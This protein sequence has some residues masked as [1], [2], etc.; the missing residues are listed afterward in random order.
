[1]INCPNKSLPEFQALISAYGEGR[2]TAA[3]RNNNEAIPTVE[4]AATLLGIASPNTV[5]ATLKIV[6]ALGTDKTQKLYDKFYKSNPEKFY[7]ELTPLA[8]K[9]QVELLRQYNSAN[10]PGSLQDMLAG[11]LADL[12]YTVEIETAKEKIQ[13]NFGKKYNIVDKEFFEYAG[14]TY[15]I[16]TD[17]DGDRVYLKDNKQVSYVD[18]YEPALE[19][20]RE[21]VAK[22]EDVEKEKPT[23]YYSNL[24]VPG[25]TNYTENEIATPGITPSIKGHA[26]FSTDNGIGWF[27]SDDK[28][29]F[30]DDFSKMSNKEIEKL[31]QEAQMSIDE[32]LQA[33]NYR[34]GA[35]PSKTRRIL[36]VQSD[37]FQKGR[38]K[39][40]LITTD[41]DW[42]ESSYMQHLLSSPEERNKKENKKK[43]E[44]Q[45]LQLLNKDGNW[46]PF[47]IKSIVQDSAKKGYEK[48]LFPTGDTA[49]KI[50][51]H[52][53][54]EDFKKEKESRIKELE[55]EKNKGFKNKFIAK[56]ESGSIIGEADTE[57]VVRDIASSFGINNPIIE[58][59]TTEI[60]I[61][62][63]DREIQQLQEELKRVETEG[64]GALKPIYDFYENRVG[65]TLRKIY[66][67]DKVER[68]KDEYGNEW[69]QV[70]VVPEVDKST[71]FYQLGTSEVEQADKE[72]NKIIEG[73]IT[74][75]GGTIT[76]T[77]DIIINGE[78]INAN[79]VADVIRKAIQVADGKAKIDTLPE[80]AAHIFI[81]WLPK[82][83][84][85]RKKLMA[86]VRN[87]PEYKKV[88]REYKNN[89]AYQNEDGTVNEEK[90]AIETAGQI[91]AGAIVGRYKDSKTM[92]LLD[93][94]LRWIKELLAGKD[95][96]AYQVAAK[97]I[98]AGSTGKLDL[99]QSFT[100]E[101]YYYQR[102][103]EYEEY[104]QKL[105][106]KGTDAQKIVIKKLFFDQTVKRE[107]DKGYKD[108]EGNSYN[109]V[110]SRIY[111]DSG[112][113]DQYKINAEWGKQVDKILE[114]IL[115]NKLLSEIE[116]L[117]VPGTLIPIATQGVMESFYRDL[118][119]LVG[120]LTADGSIALAQ[121]VT[122][123]PFDNDPSK[124]VAGSIDILIVHPNGDTTVV[125]LKTASKKIKISPTQYSI[126]YVT[127][128]PVGKGSL[129]VDGQN[130]G[131]ST[132]KKD[133][134]GIQVGSYSKMNRLQ[135]VEIREP[136]TF[137]YFL[138]TKD[139]V[140]TGYESEGTVEHKISENRDLVDKIVPVDYTGYK[141]D[142]GN[143]LEKESKEDLLSEE[144]MIAQEKL[145]KDNLNDTI[146]NL[147]ANTK[148]FRTFLE[149]RER[150]TNLGI[151]KQTMSSID[152]LLA[153][154]EAELNT[155]ADYSTV[156]TVFLNAAK[157]QL[158]RILPYI[159]RR[160]AN[161]DLVNAN[162]TEFPLML[163]VIAE[164]MKTFEDLFILREV[165]TDYQLKVY[166]QVDQLLRDTSTAL[167]SAQSYVAD[168]Y[169]MDNAT[170]QAVKNEILQSRWKGLVY[171]SGLKTLPDMTVLGKELG[172]LGGN[173]IADLILK[174]ITEAKEESRENTERLTEK[175]FAAANKLR[176][177][178]ITNYDFMKQIGDDGKWN[179]LAVNR[180]G[181]NYIKLRRAAEEGN[182]DP[183]TGTY[184]K[185]R[186]ILDLATALAEDILYNKNLWLRKQAL[187]SFMNAETLSVDPNTGKVII[188]N[189]MYHKYTDQFK[190]ERNEY[191]IVKI[192][193]GF[194]KW[195][196]RDAT[197]ISDEMKDYLAKEYPGVPVTRSWEQE[198][199]KWRNR[200]YVENPYTTLVKDDKGNITGATRE[201]TGDAAWFPIDKHV[202]ARLIAGNGVKLASD[203]YIKLVQPTTTVEKAQAEYYNTY[204]EIM[205]MLM[206]YLP[207]EANYWFSQGNV[208]FLQANIMNRLSE[209]GADKMTI[210]SSVMKEA[211]PSAYFKD[212][213]EIE[214]SRQL[215]LAF[216]NGVQD[217]A[218][219]K[220]L[221]NEL[222]TLISNKDTMSPATYENRHN[223]IVKALDRERSKMSAQKFH[224][225]L[226]DGIVAFIK[227]AE[228]FIALSKAQGVLDIL[229]K[230]VD[231]LNFTSPAGFFTK[232]TTTVK[233]ID[234]R[235]KERIKWFMDNEFY[236]DE[237]VSKTFGDWFVKKL[238]TG[239]SIMSIGANVTGMIN[240]AFI[241]TLNNIIES[242]G[243]DF[244]RRESYRRMSKLYFS[245]FLPGY[246][247]TLGQHST[248]DKSKS[249]YGNK[250]AG[251]KIEALVIEFNM[252]DQ[253][254][255]RPGSDSWMGKFFGTLGY[256]GYEAGEYMVQSLIGNSILDSTMI[257]GYMTDSKGNPLLDNNGEKI[258][259]P[260]LSVFDAYE[261]D[262]N[263]G[264]VKLKAGYSLAKKEKYSI[265]HKI[266]KTN[267]RIHANTRW[268]VMLERY[269]VG[270]MLLQFHKWVF[271]NF[272][273][274]FELPKYNE[275]LGMDVEGRYITLWNF[276]KSLAEL[277]DRAQA[278]D[279]LTPLQKNNLK[280]DLADAL[281]VAALFGMYYVLRRIADGIPDDDP[282]IK[283]MVNWLSREADRGSQ[284]LSLFIPIWGTIEGWRLIKNPI[285][286]TSSIGKFVTL[287]TDMVQYP[288]QDDE[289]RYYQR[290]VFSGQLKVKKAAYDIIPIYKLVNEWTRLGQ[291][292]NFFIQ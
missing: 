266:W 195:V 3:W 61:A 139:G 166:K 187:N 226:T 55:K 291:Q 217:V 172:S 59:N 1:M 210:L 30:S 15:K 113:G 23:Q 37:L 133:N 110:T 75:L 208:P 66:G 132:S 96:D 77:G 111:G 10:N 65:N 57:I 76:Y 168:K 176:E 43:R 238:M 147:Y 70:P 87:R 81:H 152:D 248:R 275:A 4:Q 25:G 88:M 63:I 227:M 34:P 134:Y 54:L 93:K 236:S 203:K 145:Q 101:E 121:V 74:S 221:E 252:I 137:N 7:S 127:R 155:G 157:D 114:G 181:P 17:D 237:K 186:K 200:N 280:K 178:S 257:E 85:L 272:L 154:I 285:A 40:D 245:E 205:E 146:I 5:N 11:I 219:L 188:E 99:T 278:W 262:E 282:Y 164:Y 56:T 220:F 67:K 290:G 138:K 239:T 135:G 170:N 160:D 92:S 129:L 21:A 281:F 223:E 197:N 98:L 185:Y 141:L 184:Y 228:N 277:K 175:I 82:N 234:S 194:A 162:E 125:D 72:L 39:E 215:P 80:E 151:F 216:M 126:S 233:G 261:F 263:T 247:K 271:P 142:L 109:G 91:L 112:L 28:S 259:A 222:A 69:Y 45:F 229:D 159:S 73:F 268:K 86:D 274:R 273:Q 49:S 193:N 130:N 136:Y 183:V 90:I 169:I 199:V 119:I 58:K 78:K 36:E 249:Y 224:P 48:V 94:F 27:R 6:E 33:R 206:K 2:A 100:G 287:I 20:K 24:T 240:N 52:S 14:S 207:P 258:P 283:K 270:K 171:Q 103:P 122:A 191:M 190:S 115:Q 265:T 107:E 165:G 60:Q 204:I 241:A 143:Y 161:G 253:E 120:N 12:S 38:D 140:I 201:V 42:S 64:F 35:I 84:A 128:R 95:F 153:A 32:L 31:A 218:R 53:T 26:Q 118:S 131:L 196:F 46:I 192:T 22:G 108:A 68:I 260:K 149:A 8:G 242:I 232:G 148:K 244:F 235:T 231:L 189:G 62:N 83:S 167:T 163:G 97:Q 179:G 182:R 150:A 246:V 214:Q 177:L 286:V 269:A 211:I 44:N 41:L 202:E 19:A 243:S 9:Q 102:T 47:F 116:T 213:G 124:R 156:Y 254:Y 50:E 180:L 51:G 173:T 13:T 105:A 123:T 79:A 276:L 264:T 288:F 29:S 255:K 71:I 225:D 174:R 106:D 158:N 251:S 250:K 18:V 230:K 89:P 144:E 256:G 16:D 198:R 267:E 289:E 279:K 209:E 212:R 117:Y 104:V 292:S 284:E